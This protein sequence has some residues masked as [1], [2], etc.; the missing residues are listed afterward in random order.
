[1]QTFENYFTHKNKAF[2]LCTKYD[3]DQSDQ[4]ILADF[5]MCDETGE[6]VLQKDLET[7]QDLYR[8]VCT[9][10]AN[11]HAVCYGGAPA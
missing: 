9:I 5:D 7:N 4:L 2:Y 6:K 3:F 1:M 11:E 10:L 8:Q